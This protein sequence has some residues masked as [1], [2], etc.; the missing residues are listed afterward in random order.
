MKKPKKKA[1][2]VDIAKE[3]QVSNTLVSMVLS[4]NGAKHRVSKDTIKRILETAK[5]MGYNPNMLARA[6]RTGKSGV[7]GLIVADISNPFYAMIARLLENEAFKYEYDMMFA[8]SDEVLEK[9]IKLGNAFISRPV[10]GLIITPVIGSQEIIKEWQSNNIPIVSIDRHIK[11]LSIP[12]AVTDNYNASIEIVKF[13]TKRGY[14]KIAYIGKESNLSSFTER[15]EGFLAG[16]KALKLN[17]KNYNVFRL[18][19]YSW[20]VEIKKV[21]LRIINDGYDIIYFSQNMLGIRG[22]KILYNLNIKI[23]EEIAVISFDNPDV[24]E[25][26]KTPVTCYEQPLDI[27]AKNALQYLMKMID[28]ELIETKQYEKSKGR[29][30]VRDSC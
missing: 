24:F 4:G 19:Y 2:I 26:C 9:F 11:T 21:L 22:L 1:T 16:A 20:E 17:S 6:L 8:S 25:F 18:N 13:L 10:D 28:G 23:P 7:I 5:K 27:L 15:E 29:L 12:Y 3:L 14:K 30:I